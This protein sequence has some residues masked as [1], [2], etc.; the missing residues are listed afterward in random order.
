M[1]H[2]YITKAL[3]AL[4]LAG[5]ACSAQAA[6]RALV[7]GVNDYPDII[8]DGKAGSTSL[9]GPVADAQTF[10]DVLIK[11][12]GFDPAS[13]ETLTDAAATREKI[14]GEFQAWLIDG[15]KPGDRVVFYYAGHGARIAVKNPDGSARLTSTI[16]PADAKGNLDGEHP[17]VTGMIRGD[18]I[19]ALLARLA[20]RQ[21]TVVADSCN[22]G[23]I[24]RGEGGLDWTAGMR[25]LTPNMPLDMT[26]EQASDDVIGQT[27]IRGRFIDVVGTEDES[28]RKIAV[29]ASNDDPSL[30]KTSNPPTPLAA[31]ATPTGSLAVWSAATLAQ[32]TFDDPDKPGGV[33]TQSLAARLRK[34]ASDPSGTDILTVGELLQ[35]VRS[36]ADRYCK[37]FGPKCA[38]GLT[39]ELQAPDDY[40]LQVL[41]PGSKSPSPAPPKAAEPQTAV[42]SAT[43]VAQATV[44]AAQALSH[45]NDF[46]LSAEILP[47]AHA[48]LG[49]EVRFRIASAEAGTLVVLDRGPDGKLTQIFPNKFSSANAKGGLIRANAPVVIPDASYGFAFVPTDAGKGDLLVLVAEPD[50]DLHTLVADELAFKPTGDPKALLA[51]LTAKLLSPRLDPSADPAATNRA[52]RW[53]FATVAYEI[54]K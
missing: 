18:E 31:A 25:T 38:N 41:A 36:E 37:I 1:Q 11:I 20:D 50:I 22:S 42:A 10:K 12:F 5:V 35:F 27:K 13:I 44:L 29:V 4:A 32:V 46:A 28:G 51:G 16:V 52:R 3:I 2:K 40:F 15:S 45:D 21:V 34:A 30:G 48:K 53:A 43:A 14:L 54:G 49:Q 8:R 26:S 39:P 24:S 47:D 7:I 33:F 19:G 17:Q 23:S 6:D 9:G